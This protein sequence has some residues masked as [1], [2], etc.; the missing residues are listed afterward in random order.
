MYMELNKMATQYVGDGKHPN[1]Y[2]VSNRADV[3][4]V[5]TDFEIAYRAWEKLAYRSPRL[6]CQLEDRLNGILASVEFHPETGRLE[7]FDDTRER[8]V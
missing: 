8:R 1:L 5:S 4:T 3:V 7:I 6:E 2:F